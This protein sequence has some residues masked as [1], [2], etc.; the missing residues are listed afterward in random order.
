[1]VRKQI[2]Y[3]IL[4]LSTGEP[5]RYLPHDVETP[6]DILCLFLTDFV[7]EVFKR[8]TNKYVGAGIDGKG[9]GSPSF[10]FDDLWRS[11]FLN[12]MRGLFVLLIHLG[13]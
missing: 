8:E 10:S 12:K 5:G 2:W 6:Y 3:P 4:P 7:L 1:M 13:S 11:D 9:D